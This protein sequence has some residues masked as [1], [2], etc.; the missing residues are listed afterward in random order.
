[1]TLKRKMTHLGVQQRGQLS[2]LIKNITPSRPVGVNVRSA[3]CQLHLEKKLLAAP[4]DCI[5][6]SAYAPSLVPEE[7]CLSSQELP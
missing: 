6:I 3:G 1:V 7:I 4:P 5:I 2:N